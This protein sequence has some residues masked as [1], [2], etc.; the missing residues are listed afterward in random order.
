MT[1]KFKLKSVTASSNAITGLILDICLFSVIFSLEIDAKAARA[2]DV[3]TGRTLHKLS[4][5]EKGEGCPGAKKSKTIRRYY[6]V[7]EAVWKI[8][9]YPLRGYE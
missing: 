4:W 5:G 2:F 8:L 1:A 7:L 6:Q 3:T 9:K